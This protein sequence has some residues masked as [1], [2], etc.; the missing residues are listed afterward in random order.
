MAAPPTKIDRETT[1]P[2][3]LK[4]FYRTGSHHRIEDF[5]PTGPQPQHVIIYTWP[6]ATLTELSSLISNNLPHLLPSP[7]IGTRL[8]FELVFP[9]LAAPVRGDGFGRYRKKPL[10]SIVLGAGA[11]PET[12]GHANGEEEAPIPVEREDFVTGDELK[13]LQDAKFVIGD[14][15]DCAILPPLPNGDVA[16]PPR[17][18]APM[19]G[20]LGPPLRENGFGVNGGFGVRRGRGGFSEGRGG[21]GVPNGEWRRGDVPPSGGFGRGGGR[22]RGRGGW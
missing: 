8:D 5:H 17:V 4:L 19:S 10:G 20:R 21:G 13:S 15:V 1:T 2:F 16:P 22:G 18:A 3:L 12:N 7:S 11:N 14:Y 6:S 9:D